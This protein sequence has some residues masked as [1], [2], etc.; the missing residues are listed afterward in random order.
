MFGLLG[1]EMEDDNLATSHMYILYLIAS[2]L[3]YVLFVL[4]K[5]KAEQM[6]GLKLF[7]NPP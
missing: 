1:P 6:V 2:S 5:L 4:I 3:I 7:S